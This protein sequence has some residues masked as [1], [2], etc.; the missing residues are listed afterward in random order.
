LSLLAWSLLK[1]LAETWRVTR[2]LFRLRKLSSRLKDQ[3][4]NSVTLFPLT[5]KTLWRYRLRPNNR[6]TTLSTTLTLPT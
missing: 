4:L 6:T 2:L 1:S 3:P 5:T